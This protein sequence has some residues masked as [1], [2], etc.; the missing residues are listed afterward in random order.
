MCFS[1]TA[2]FA[3]GTALI[4][5]GGYLL[6]KKQHSHESAMASIPAIFGLQQVIEGFVW[7][8]FAGTIPEW[9]HQFSIYA[10]SFFATSFWPA[11]IPLAVYLFETPNRSNSPIQTL[12]L[13]AYVAL[14]F[15]V[16]LYLLWSSTLYSSLIASVQCNQIDCNSIGYQYD[17]PYLKQYINFIYLSCIVIPFACSKNMIVRYWVCAVFFASFVIGALLSKATTF[18]SV[19]CFFAAVMSICIIP[20]INQN[21]PSPLTV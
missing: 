1:A 8:G 10:F 17:L 13:R 15:F 4:A 7:I 16:G 18:P 21:R 11:F 5:V 14:G 12:V 20:A 3:S 6:H 2:S 9:L 19:W